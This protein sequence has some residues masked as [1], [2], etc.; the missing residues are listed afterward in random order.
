MPRHGYSLLNETKLFLEM[1]EWKNDHSLVVNTV[2]LKLLQM[3]GSV[4]R[5]VI[6]KNLPFITV[7]LLPSKMQCITEVSQHSKHNVC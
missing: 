3:L 5:F 1:K 6:M 2:Y 4:Y 7:Q